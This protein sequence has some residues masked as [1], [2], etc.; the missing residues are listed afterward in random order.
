MQLCID[1][2]FIVI[3]KPVTKP[4]PIDPCKRSQQGQVLPPQGETW[5]SSH[6]LPGVTASILEPSICSIPQTRWNHCQD[7]Y[8]DLGS[9]PNGLFLIPILILRIMAFWTQKTM[10]F[11]FLLKVW[12]SYGG[13]TPGRDHWVPRLPDHQLPGYLL[14]IKS[15]PLSRPTKS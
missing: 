5:C 7:H 1:K 14:K 12:I 13:N 4:T 3:W 10:F 9:G 2:H 6:P 8:K 11:V 15:Q